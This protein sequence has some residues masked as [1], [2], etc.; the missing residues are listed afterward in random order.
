MS[1]SLVGFT[2]FVGSNI[3]ARHAFDGLY[4]SANIAGAYGTKPDLLIYSAVPAAKFLAD[5]DPEADMSV[6]RAA[7]ENIKKIAPKRLVLI[8]TVDVYQNSDG[9]DENTPADENN[10]SA[11][12]R[13]RAALEA[14]VRAQYPDALI[15]RLPALFGAG[16]KK[17][18][19]Y[20]Y[21]HRTP[22]MLT[23]QKY[24]EIAGQNSL[25]ADAYEQAE[26]GFY[27]LKRCDKTVERFFAQNDFNSLCFT[28]S[29]SEYQFYDVSLLWRD[30]S[31]ALA[32]NITLLNI[33]SQPLSAADIYS[34]LTYGGVFE[35]LL[36]K[37]PAKYNM[38]S[39]YAPLYG[40]ENGYMYSAEE[41]LEALKG[42][43]N[44]SHR[45]EI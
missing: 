44:T 28:D 12:G 1:I 35:N 41:T 45:E 11:Y 22:A 33:T 43:V 18:F 40:G 7:F 5:S 13:N 30:I 42:F 14:L 31:V 29:R 9:A 3:A 21:M 27:R 6:C 37:A 17:N 38:L 2:G 24:D 16:L 32:A 15:I 34:A 10:P 36:D 26:N 8:S 39:K 20:D 19:I 4:N 23:K 25:V